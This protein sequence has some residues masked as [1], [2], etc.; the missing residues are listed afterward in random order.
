MK[1]INRILSWLMVIAVLAGMLPAG[2]VEEDGSGTDVP[3]TYANG[4]NPAPP[5][6]P[7]EGD[8]WDGS[9]TEPTTLVQKDGVY[10]YEITKCSELAYIVQNEGDWLGYNYVLG[11]NLIFNDVVIICD[12]QGLCEN[13]EK[14]KSLNPV[15]ASYGSYF[16][17]CFD[18]G[19]YVISGLYC[20]NSSGSSYSGMFSSC[21]DAILKNITI[22]NSRIST[23]SDAG[24]LAGYCGDSTIENCFF[25]GCVVSDQDAAGG[26]IGIIVRSQITNCLS[27][28][29]VSGVTATGGLV[30]RCN[31]G[32][33][34]KCVSYAIV[35]GESNVGGLIGEDFNS[36]L[37]I[38]D[39]ASFG[40]AVG[41]EAVGGF[42]G[43][44]YNVDIRNS[45][46][47]GDVVATAGTAGGFA[48]KTEKNY[49]SIVNCFSAGDVSSTAYAGGFVGSWPSE[50][51][52][53]YSVGTVAST[54]YAGGFMGEDRRIWGEDFSVENCYYIKDSNNNEELFGT[55]IATADI[56][57]EIEGKT[58]GLL[59]SQATFSSWDFDTIW[60]ISP[61]K[62]GGYPYLQWQESILSEV[63]VSGVQISENSLTLAEGDYTYLTATVSP[64][65][66]SNQS[67]SWSTSDPT[68]AAVSTAGKV[69]AVAPG[70]ATITVTTKDGGFTA[71]CTVTVTERMKEEYKINGITIRDNEGAV[72]SE[73]PV[74]SSLATV[75]ITNLASEGNTLVLLA[76]YTSDGK[77]HGMMWV[78][79]EDMPIGATINLTLPMNNANGKI[80]NLK[81]FA[82][83]SFADPTPLSKAA[84]FLSCDE[85]AGE[86]TASYDDA[87]SGEEY[88]LLV[89]KRSNGDDRVINADT[90]L[91]IDQKTAGEDGIHF[92]YTPKRIPDCEILL[93]GNFDNT[94]SPVVL[95][96]MAAQGPAPGDVNADGLV[97][98]TDT[99]LIFRYVSGTTGFTDEQ[100]AAADVNGDGTVNGTDTN[101]VFRFVSGTLES[102]D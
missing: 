86:Y 65:N 21:R 94:Q 3:T 5:E 1:K 16:T 4:Y 61:D 59:K 63:A 64:T 36:S 82:V 22:V 10:Y 39:C 51:S 44:A 43:Y 23:N 17:G 101:L 32:D 56:D 27:D 89:V 85:V 38:S 102:F 83:A 12:E 29:S 50:I 19:G 84:S 77:Y 20:Q 58:S 7:T 11:N 98:G 37:L 87:V 92:E 100:L 26:L 15:A 41:R 88:V 30:G 62:N 93:V 8:V 53:S 14:L 33:I 68:I 54:N 28:G 48:G 49:S 79:V 6:I 99:N 25:S 2:A 91:Y 76:M 95:G 70:T 46:S 52:R 9:I 81:A 80:A 42:L 57:G 97:N 31:G 74:G 47:F 13:A 73:V 90:I 71:S 75:S 40:D 34:S 67:V 55:S 18:G 60:S 69:T 72:L 66:A 78:N 35:C 24:G 96:T 45:S